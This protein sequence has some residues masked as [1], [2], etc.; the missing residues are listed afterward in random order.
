VPPQTP[1]P[2]RWPPPPP[3]SPPLDGAARGVGR[4]NAGWSP[5]PSHRPPRPP[6]PSPRLSHR[7]RRSTWVTCRCAREGCTR[8]SHRARLCDAGQVSWRVLPAGRFERQGYLSSWRAGADSVLSEEEASERKVKTFSTG[9]KAIHLYSHPRVFPDKSDIRGA[10]RQ[11]PSSGN[12][13][14]QCATTV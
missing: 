8:T 4:R 10:S 3:S 6:T 2:T 12:H 14:H 1:D 5:A 7:R 13:Q 9:A 11:E